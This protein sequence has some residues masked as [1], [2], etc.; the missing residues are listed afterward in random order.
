LCGT[1]DRIT[2]N[3]QTPRGSDIPDSDEAIAQSYITGLC[4][5]SPSKVNQG[6]PEVNPT[7][8]CEELLNNASEFTNCRNSKKL[9]FNSLISRCVDMTR[10]DVRRSPLSHCSVI[11]AVMRL[12]AAA[13]PSL[14]VD[15]TKNA[16]LMS[17]GML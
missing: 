10:A 12:C 11:T 4:T 8:I 7:N 17:C 5:K 1:Y 3:D 13:D 9:D 15:A 14:K 6:V 16:R 2:S